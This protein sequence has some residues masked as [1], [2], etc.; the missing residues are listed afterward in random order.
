MNDWKDKCA[1]M[2]KGMEVLRYVDAED[3]EVASMRKIPS[4]AVIAVEPFKTDA[5]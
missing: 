3:M 4:V 1:F 2:P 5:K